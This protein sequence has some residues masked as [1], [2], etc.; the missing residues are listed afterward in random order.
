MKL[1]LSGTVTSLPTDT[2]SA[3]SG[4]WAAIGHCNDQFSVFK[5]SLQIFRFK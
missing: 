5:G 4:V 2:D 3:V 1:W